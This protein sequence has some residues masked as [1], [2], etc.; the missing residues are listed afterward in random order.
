MQ[1]NIFS[2]GT[3][4]SVRLLKELENIFEDLFGNIGV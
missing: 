1:Q 3:T 2:V 4:E